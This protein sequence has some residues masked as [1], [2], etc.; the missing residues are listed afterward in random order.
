MSASASLDNEAIAARLEEAAGLLEIAVAEEEGMLADG[1][2][3]LLGQV[4]EALEKLTGGFDVEHTPPTKQ[5][6]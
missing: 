1:D 4:L 2:S 6:G 3:P 5:G